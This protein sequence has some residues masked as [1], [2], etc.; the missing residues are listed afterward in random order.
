MRFNRSRVQNPTSIIELPPPPYYNNDVTF[1]RGKIMSKL[2]KFAIVTDQ[3]QAQPQGELITY[4]DN[5]L[6]S[7]YGFLNTKYPWLKDSVTVKFAEMK[8]KEGFA[9]AICDVTFPN[10]PFVLQFPLIYSNGEFLDVPSFYSPE[11]KM[12]IPFNEDWFKLIVDN[13]SESSPMGKLTNYIDMPGPT[14]YAF[15]TSY[16]NTTLSR[17]NPNYY[18]FKYGAMVASSI[19]SMFPASILKSMVKTAT[20]KHPELIK[21]A[22]SAMRMSEIRHNAKINSHL[23]K[24]AMVKKASKNESIIRPT[25]VFFKQSQAVDLPESLRKYMNIDRSA[26]Y[27][28]LGKS[29][30][31]AADGANPPAFTM[32]EDEEISMPLNSELKSRFEVEAAVK[33]LGEGKSTVITDEIKSK[34][35]VFVNAKGITGGGSR[36][37]APNTYQHDPV[38]RTYYSNVN[39]PLTSLSDAV[40]LT[41]PT[42]RAYFTDNTNY[43]VQTYNYAKRG[44]ILDAVFSE[45]MTLKYLK[46]LFEIVF[47]N[48][49]SAGKT[50]VGADFDK[51]KGRDLFKYGNTICSLFSNCYCYTCCVDIS[52]L[53]NGYTK[54]A[55]CS[56]TGDNAPVSSAANVSSTKTPKIVFIVNKDT[57]KIEKIKVVNGPSKSGTEVYSNS[58]TPLKCIA[59]ENIPTKEEEI[60]DMCGAISVDLKSP[61]KT[62]L[63]SFDRHFP[64]NVIDS[65]FSD[66]ASVIKQMIKGIPVTIQRDTKTVEGD[67]R[68]IFDRDAFRHYMDV[69]VASLRDVAMTL[70]MLGVA[71]K[72]INAITKKAETTSDFTFSLVPNASYGKTAGQPNPDMGQQQVAPQQPA[73]QQDSSGSVSKESLDVIEKQLDM[74]FKFVQQQMS[75]LEKGIADREG[76][77]AKQLQLLDQKIQSVEGM[78]AT[79]DETNKRVEEVYK[80]MDQKIGDTQ[81]AAQEAA[82]QQVPAQ[83]AQPA[84]PAGAPASAPAAGAPQQ[85]TPTIDDQTA[86]MLAQ[87]AIDPNA[88]AQNG[89]DQPTVQLIMGAINGDPQSMQQLGINNQDGYLI[90]QQYNTLVSQQQPS[91][92]APAAPGQPPA[93]PGQA[94]AAPAGVAPAG[95]PMGA[96]AGQ[97][98]GPA[99]QQ[100]AQP[101]MSPTQVQ[102]Q[103]EMLASALVDPSVASQQG[104]ADQDL[105]YL[106]QIVEDPFAAKQQGEDPMFVDALLSA[107]NRVIQ[108]Y[109]MNN[110]DLTS[111]NATTMS[112]PNVE[113]AAGAAN[114][115]ED[116]GAADEAAFMRNMTMLGDLIPKIKSSKLFFKYINNFKSMLSIL[117][118]LLFS[119]ELQSTKYQKILGESSFNETISLLQGLYDQF[120]EFILKMY[121]MEKQQ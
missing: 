73:P 119:L 104:I 75:G 65:L 110:A 61:L 15:R 102:E 74:L 56:V 30:Y 95:A 25:P 113:G 11:N 45:E 12:F 83:Q 71:A 17:E 41:V 22:Y 19:L 89:I 49:F 4:K 118:E 8:P 14:D 43:M 106:R 9:Y 35:Y 99:A 6:Q 90:A 1:D 81:V 120:G 76:V 117:G 108:G 44:A 109:M 91:A 69:K 48:S 7:A 58:E 57:D 79:L 33:A 85:E 94:P 88:A 16:Y 77:L 107:Y 13:I 63:V 28:A 52:D 70:G 53:G 18:P 116:S 66:A 59:I 62:A 3:S 112:T 20:S 37:E 50:Y 54:V 47:G 64:E 46:K 103:A 51:V 31:Y 55:L 5:L 96:P 24:T 98:Q 121:T 36:L 2:K 29:A 105:N 84:A 82:T 67:Y 10:S 100:P 68:I 42:D 114:K 72:D 32:L 101:P 80:E 97:P 21:T 34:T 26:M 27:S 40:N 38:K 39:N 111:Q 60:V 86:Q 92:A 87:S 93:Q 78:R 23:S 115:L